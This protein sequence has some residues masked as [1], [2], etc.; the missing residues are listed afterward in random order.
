MRYDTVLSMYPTI[1]C[2]KATMS[3]FNLENSALGYL[4]I[5]GVTSDSTAKTVDIIAENY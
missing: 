3:T 5:L 2:F 1:G 4:N